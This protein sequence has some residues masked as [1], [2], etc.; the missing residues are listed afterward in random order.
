MLRTKTIALREPRFTVISGGT[1]WNNLIDPFKAH[2]DNVSYIMPISDNGGS[3]RKIL[4]VFGGPGIGDIRSRLVRLSTQ[5]TR[6]AAAVNKLLEHRLYST[7]QT[8]AKNEWENL[9]N[10]SSLLWEGISDSHK[11]YIHRYFL[12]IENERH[13]ARNRFDFKGASVGN[14]YFTGLRLFFNKLSTAI[15]AFSQIASVPQNTKVLPIFDNVEPISI[16]AELEDG[17]IIM[18]QNEISHPGESVNKDYSDPLPA[19]I[20]K[21]FYINHFMNPVSPTADSAVLSDLSEQRTLIYSMGSL[22]TSII[23][24]LIARGVGEEI[25]LKP[26]KK[27]LILNGHNDRETGN[28][29]SLEH[30]HHITRAANRYGELNYAPSDYISHLIVAD[31]TTIA[32]KS[33]EIE[34]LG[35]KIVPSASI[36]DGDKALYRAEELVSSIFEIALK[37]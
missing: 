4:N 12:W 17:S 13:L 23:P 6:E 9:L 14:L 16:G 31:Q 28:A 24:P 36:R 8:I 29:S 32:H 35:I 27:I 2:T 10:G 33:S 7:S 34:D 25:A 30:I 3:T 11:E 15:F 19:R 1:A 5:K 18:G 37:D 26:D 20:K 22:F 21:M